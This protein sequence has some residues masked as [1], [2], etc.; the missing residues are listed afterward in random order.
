MVGE[1]GWRENVASSDKR[2]GEQGPCPRESHGL[3]EKPTLML[4]RRQEEVEGMQ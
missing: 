2:K 4:S 3:R 1:G